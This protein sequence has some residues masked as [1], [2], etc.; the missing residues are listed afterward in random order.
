VGYEPAP[1]SSLFTAEVLGEEQ[2]TKSY[3]KLKCINVGEFISSNSTTE[4]TVQNSR[5]RYHAQ[6][7]PTQTSAAAQPHPNMQTIE[8]LEHDDKG[9][10]RESTLFSAHWPPDPPGVGAPNYTN[11]RYSGT[12]KYPPETKGAPP[13]WQQPVA[14][15]PQAH[16]HQT[17]QRVNDERNLTLA[18]NDMATAIE[19]SS[20]SSR[21]TAAIVFA[22]KSQEVHAA[23]MRLHSKPRQAEDQKAASIELNKIKT[24]LTGYQYPRGSNGTQPV[25]RAMIILKVQ[26]AIVDHLGECTAIGYQSLLK[27]NTQLVKLVIPGCLKDSDAIK[28]WFSLDDV[29]VNEQIVIEVNRRNQEEASRQ[30]RIQPV[31]LMSRMTRMTFISILT[32]FKILGPMLW[33]LVWGD[34]APEAV[35][36]LVVAFTMIE[37]CHS[38]PADNTVRVIELLHSQS[39]I[40]DSAAEFVKL[41]EMMWQ[42]NNKSTMS[43]IRRALFFAFPNDQRLHPNNET[44]DAT[45]NEIIIAMLTHMKPAQVA[46]QLLRVYNDP[47]P[48]SGQVPSKEDITFPFLEAVAE[49]YQAR[50]NQEEQ[51]RATVQRHVADNNKNNTDMEHFMITQEEAENEND[52][53][54]EHFMMAQEEADQENNI[55]REHFMVTHED[56]MI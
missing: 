21:Y 56:I 26:S 31:H 19:E 34:T 55:A 13:Y 12:P 35:D 16:G 2:H 10:G 51:R 45:R 17:N 3:N 4:R 37:V 42:R 9:R 33:K 11:N 32:N 41:V 48:Q 50:H 54:M 49:S 46:R 43:A 38:D 28:T 40:P 15:S 52:A 20:T 25:E 44:T 14:R 18:V 22:Q 6:Q 47:Q 39:Q 30:G 8:P 5:Y 24:M 53:A 36:G 1:F 23:E 29:Y 7:G 27:D